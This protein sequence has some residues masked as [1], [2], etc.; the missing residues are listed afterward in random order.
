MQR[1]DDWHFGGLDK[2]QQIASGSPTEDSVFML[3]G[4]DIVVTGI[5]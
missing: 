2:V 5:E 3:N 1:R 4:E